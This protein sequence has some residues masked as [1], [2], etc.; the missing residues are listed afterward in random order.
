MKF[1]VM[2]DLQWPFAA[3]VFDESGKQVCSIAPYRYGSNE[4][5]VADVD[6][7]PENAPWLEMLK[8]IGGVA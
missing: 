3:R 6:A 5:C 4:K 1:K 7:N 8:R 2:R